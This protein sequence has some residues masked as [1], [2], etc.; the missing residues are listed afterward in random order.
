MRFP[1]LINFPD[2]TYGLFFMQIFE[3]THAHFNYVNERL[4]IKNIMNWMG[5]SRI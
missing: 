1:Y 5:G 4:T 3:D 2:E